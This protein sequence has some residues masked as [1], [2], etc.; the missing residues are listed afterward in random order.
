M[1]WRSRRDA[2]LPPPR[3]RLAGSAAHPRLSGRPHQHAA[4]QARHRLRRPGATHRRKYRCYSPRRN[5]RYSP[6]RN[7]RRYSPNRKNRHPVATRG[8]AAPDR[9]SASGRGMASAAETGR[10]ARAPRRRAGGTLL[11]GRRTPAPARPC[12]TKYDLVGSLGAGRRSA[13]SVPLLRAD[14]PASVASRSSPPGRDPPGLGVEAA[15]RPRACDRARDERARG[16]STILVRAGSASAGPE[17][18]SA[19]EPQGSLGRYAAVASFAVP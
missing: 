14:A 11:D 16:P 18:C 8:L 6:S 10:A 12:L 5:D 2:G 7:D 3:P 9:A 13:S 19:S 17:K 1:Q 4:P 15:P